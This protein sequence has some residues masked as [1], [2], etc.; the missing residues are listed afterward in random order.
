MNF[1]PYPYLR[2]DFRR[3]VFTCATGMFADILGSFYRASRHVF[4]DK[5]AG[6]VDLTRAYA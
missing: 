2:P 4:A 3:Y 6:S 1:D 5:M